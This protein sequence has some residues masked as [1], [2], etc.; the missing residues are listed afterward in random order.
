VIVE[1]EGADG[2]QVAGLARL[3]WLQEADL[4]EFRAVRGR[5]AGPSSCC[6]AG[7]R[8]LMNVTR[9]PGE[10]VTFCGET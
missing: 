5:D 3:A 7:C 9:V 6:A 8:C 4:I 2:V 1:A 10:T